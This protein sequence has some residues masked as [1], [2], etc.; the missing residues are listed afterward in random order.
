MSFFALLPDMQPMEE[1][2]SGFILR[3]SWPE[4]VE[5]G[6]RI[7]RALREADVDRE[8]EAFAEWSEWR[9][10]AHERLGDDVS[11]KTAEQASVAEGEG[12]QAGVD[13]DEDLLTAG[14][15]LSESYERAEEGDG[16]AAVESWGESIDHVARAADS[17][18]RKAL[19]AVENTVY[20][21]VMTQIAP[22]YF[23]NELISANVQRIGSR[24]DPTYVLEV[25]VNDDSLKDEVREHLTAF[26]EEVDRWHIDTEKR[27]DEAA[28]AEGAEP[29]TRERE[30]GEHRGHSTRN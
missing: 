6:E 24:V 14:E 19:R 5:H 16:D 21:R 2:V 7:S 10:K 28:A 20:R 1:S 4:I 11:E 30:G 25:N 23:D 18:G 9:P 15:K 26:D 17:A 8:N 27:V 3:G 22:Y 12:E 13:P 29:P